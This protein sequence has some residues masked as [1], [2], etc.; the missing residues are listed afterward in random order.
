MLLLVLLGVF[1]VVA[2]LS[3]FG[4]TADSR[5]LRPRLPLQARGLRPENDRPESFSHTALPPF[6]RARTPYRSARGRRRR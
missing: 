5:D 6:R 1:V 4:M 2:I 3:I